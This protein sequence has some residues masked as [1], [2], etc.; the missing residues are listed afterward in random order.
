MDYSQYLAKP[1]Q[2][3]VEHAEALITV[4]NKLIE[5]GY[6][7][8]SYLI[9]LVKLACI[10]HDDGKANPVFQSRIKTSTKFNED[11]EVPHNVLSGYLLNPKEFL[12]EEDYYY[13][14]FA[15]MYHHNYG[16][17]YELCIHKQE[18][19][20]TLLNDFDY[21][22]LKRKELNK[23]AKNKK[24]STAIKVKGYLHKCDYSASGKYEVEYPNDFL[25]EGL[26]HLK[27]KWQES[28]S[29]SDWND[30]QKFAMNHS[31]KNVI[32][33]AQ[34]GMGKT[35]AGLHWIGN[36][37]GY[38]VLPLR[39]AINAMYERILNDILRNKESSNKLSILHSESLEYYFKSYQDNLTN[40]LEYEKRG[41]RLSM[42]LNI[43]TMDQM[44]DFIFQYQGYEAKLITFSYSKIVIDEIQMY[45]PELL[46]CLIYGLK[47][48]VDFGG[49][50][51]IMTA[52]L[53]PFI[54][55]LL[56]KEIPFEDGCIATF[57]NELIRHNVKVI[58]DYINPDDIVEHYYQNLSE[59]KSNK[60]L[61]VCNTIRRAQEVYRILKKEV[62]SNEVHLLHSRYT[63]VDRLI[64]E[65]EILEFGRTFDEKKNLDLRS[66]IWISTSLVEA[67][68]DIDFDYLYTELQDLNSLFQRMGRC[69]RKGVKAVDTY[70][71]YIYLK[72]SNEYIDQTIF[73]L[74]R[75]AIKNIDG[76]LSEKKKIELIDTYFTSENLQ[77]SDYYL[78]KN[79]YKNTMEWLESIDPYQ[80]E[81]NDNKLR[82][83]LTIEVI[84]H[85]VFLT[86]K[87]K[88]M[89]ALDRMKEDTNSYLDR[90]R[91]KDNIMQYTVSIPY[92]MWMKYQKAVQQN[93][94]EKYQD[95]NLG[96]NEIIYVMEC[97]Y[98]ET[99]FN[100]LDYNQV[101][102]EPNII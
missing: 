7:Q 87:E 99:G 74:S 56:T 95:I 50:V 18:I 76:V 71:C 96:N 15:I 59:H 47:K 90:C 51:A 39:T 77:M 48:I 58:D 55:D 88:I 100:E 60:I 31:D 79:G 40:I 17:P 86:N 101:I 64:K 34:T 78:G 68:L 26:D 22:F 32:M 69:N 91:V 70:N 19:I 93:M 57:T 83:I 14:L 36:H 23:V 11:I 63:K 38:F 54:R 5:Y 82:N 80:Y 12:L 25:V 65:K 62:L 9:N 24:N 2:T 67:S 73:Q 61:V 6:I 98:D 92:W 21:R 45:D 89:K 10:H 84:P 75:E 43:S 3:I 53:S 81:K 27:K 49:K 1:D 30:L 44:F 72:S 28:N 97:N 42:P 41:K 13:V 33:I 35:E 37:K 52:T 29:N 46:A 102:R 85:T 4:L 8:D 94:A 20:K 66:G 16:D